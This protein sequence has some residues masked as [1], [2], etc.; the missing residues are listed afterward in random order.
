[1]KNKIAFTLLTLLFVF[2]AACTKTPSEP[3]GDGK[4][5]VIKGKLVDKDNNPIEGA[6]VSLESGDANP[7]I[8]DENGEFILSDVED[9]EHVLLIYHPD[10]QPEDK[11]ELEIT[12][13]Q[14][15]DFEDPIQMASAYYNIKGNV[16]AGASQALAGAGIAISGTDISALTDS[17]GEFDLPQVPKSLEK[18]VLLAAHSD[19]GFTSIVI[20]P[21]GEDL[22]T[23]EDIEL[24]NQN[25]VTVSGKV[26]DSEN[27]PM[28][29]ILVQAIGNGLQDTT[30]IKGE[31]LIKNIPSNQAGVRIAVPPTE[32][33]YA[34]A[35]MGFEAKPNTH[36]FGMDITLK[37]VDPKNGISFV[38]TDLI[39][40]DDDEEVRFVV[41][42][43][44]EEDI[45]VTE[46]QW[47]LKEGEVLGLTDRPYAKVLV[48]DLK[49]AVEGLDL[50]I[51][52]PITIE[53]LAKNQ[54]G[55][56]SATYSFNIT[57]RTDE[58]EFIEVGA[59][60]SKNVELMDSLSVLQGEAVSFMVKAY[61]P[62][63]GLSSLELDP[64]DESDVI[65]VALDSSFRLSHVYEEVGNYE[66]I[67]TIK[68]T[69][70]NE[71]TKKIYIEVTPSS[72]EKAQLDFPYPQ[73]VNP[74]KDKKVSFSWAPV[75]GENVSYD[76]LL[77]AV[78]DPPYTVAAENV[79][80][81]SVSLTLD[82]GVVYLWRVVAK[83]GDLISYSEIR[84]VSG[85]KE[86]NYEEIQVEP[87]N[88]SSLNNLSATFRFLHEDNSTYQIYLGFG[89]ATMAPLGDPID[90]YY[91]QDTARFVKSGLVANK[92]YVWTII[93]EDEDGVKHQS[94][95]WSFKTPNTVPTA[96]YPRSPSGS[97]ISQKSPISFS[98]DMSTDA[99]GDQLYNIIFLDTQNPPFN[100]VAVVNDTDEYVYEEGVEETGTY[101]WR[102]ATTD[103]RDTSWSSESYTRT[104]TIVS[105]GVGAD[106][107]TTPEDSADVQLNSSSRARFQWT[108]EAGLSYKFLIGESI[109][110]MDTITSAIYNDGDEKYHEEI[111]Q[112]NRQYFWTVIST[113]GQGNAVASPVR[114]IFTLNQAPSAPAP[115]SPRST[116]VLENEDIVLSWRPAVDKDEDTLTYIVY[117][118]NISARPATEIIGTTA[119]SFF[120]IEGGIDSATQFFWHVL[121]TDGQ[122]TIASGDNNWFYTNLPPEISTQPSD[123][124]ISVGI[125]YS[126]EISVND[127]DEA[128]TLNWSNISVPT[129]WSTSKVDNNMGRI[130]W[131]P[132]LSDVGEHTISIRVRD[133]NY[134]VSYD[135]VSWT[136]TVSEPEGSWDVVG[137]RNFNGGSATFQKI[138]FVG[139]VPH[140]AY[141]ESNNLFVNKYE[142]FTWLPVGADAA[143][144]DTSVYNNNIA[145]AVDGDTPYLIYKNGFS[146]YQLVAKSFGGTTWDTVGSGAFGSPYYAGSVSLAFSGGIPHVAYE[147]TGREAIVEKLNGAAWD[148]LGTGILTATDAYSLSMQVDGSNGDIY[149]A[150]RDYANTELGMRKFDGATWL[151]TAASSSDGD[152]SQVSLAVDAADN[153]FYAAFRD[154]ENGNTLTVMQYNGSG[155]D[156]VGQ[157][158]LVAINNLFKIIADNGILYVLIEE[159][160]NRLSVMKWE[161]NSWGYLGYPQFTPSSADNSD[162]AL[163]A[164]GNPWV[165]FRDGGQSNGSTVMQYSPN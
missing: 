60:T 146:P 53:V 79:E 75:V 151:G 71:K 13:G 145:F 58:P 102:V 20:T 67:I 154:T 92:T 147:N 132:T 31:Y 152:I 48:S 116:T 68:D 137:G 159:S 77:D 41:F 4:E 158:A 24:T 69:D 84:E 10:W 87:K 37:K 78:N 82:S 28:P 127:P 107:L 1:M 81:T 21:D 109:D 96:P 121:A 157:K 16:V 148:T 47:K 135:T 25:G 123:T 7:A 160:N 118:E 43:I 76:V 32:D 138:A 56:N 98:W 9:G 30:N 51:K 14:T 94:E 133:N 89:P 97:Y 93:R 57:I 149:V 122:D 108:Q 155:W 59:T 88:N 106:I 26:L 40:R 163:D 38:T 6:V 91:S 125:P 144:N 11:L 99:D 115:L 140:V 136:V 2:L 35:V 33:G 52:D 143:I 113:D 27:K 83:D 165:I 100:V 70:D 18:I 74:E 63:G 73:Y 95:I 39:V 80:G 8:T 161:D 62:F 90:Y 66:A 150:F 5:T 17:D 141:R 65:T 12:K 120:T 46:Y 119:D 101:Y 117:F 19:V 34:G 131:T 22:I 50:D 42:P 162:M 126:L 15:Y 164:S 85:F 103:G 104:I 111:L 128:Q 156:V 124:S 105:G 55:K 72:L 142:S 61:D 54:D 64:G 153:S 45:V 3:D 129:G 139:N 44:L 134:N 36:V 86:R 23:I 29:N 112:G 49:A 114:A 110:E 130:N